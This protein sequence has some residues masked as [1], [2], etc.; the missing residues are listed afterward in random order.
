MAPVIAQI[1]ETIRSG[2]P[3]EAEA[4]KQQLA[5]LKASL[6]GG[7]APT[8]DTTVSVREI[9]TKVSERCG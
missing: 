9:W 3:A 5:A 1:E 2:P 7:V 4:A 6:G 8:N